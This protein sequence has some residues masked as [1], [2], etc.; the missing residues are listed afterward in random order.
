MADKP[1]FNIPVMDCTYGAPMGRSSYGMDTLKSGAPM[2]LAELPL[3]EGYDAGGAYWGMGDQM[4]VLFNDE[5]A[6]YFRERSIASAIAELT[7]YG[8]PYNI[9]PTESDTYIL[10]AARRGYDIVSVEDG[11]YWKAK[12]EEMEAARLSDT[13]AECYENLI[14]YIGYEDEYEE[15]DDQ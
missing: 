13:M 1:I 15:P 9:I 12:S 11:Y 2:Y 3:D 10:W 7:K 8:E 6:Y 4:F 14:G 5:L